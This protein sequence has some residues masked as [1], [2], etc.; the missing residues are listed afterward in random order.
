LTEFRLI[1]VGDLMLGGKVS[2]LLPLEGPD[3]PFQGMRAPFREADC[4]FGNLETPLTDRAASTYV[5]GRPRFAAPVAF[6]ARLARAGFSV[7]SLANNHILDQG[8]M[9]L[10]D[11]VAALDV[12]GVPYIG[13]IEN[14][15]T[16]QRPVVLTRNGVRVGFLAYAQSHCATSSSPGAV[17]AQWDRIVSEVG[18]LRSAVDHVCLSIHAGYEYAPHPGYRTHR[19]FENITRLGVS[20]LLGHH[21]HIPQPMW[22]T[23]EGNLICASLGNCVSDMNDPEVSTACL[24]RAENEGNVFGPKYFA[25]VNWGMA[26]NVLLDAHSVVEA[27]H[28]PLQIGSK[29][30]PS[31]YSGPWPFSLARAGVLRSVLIESYYQ[32]GLL[33]KAPTRRINQLLRQN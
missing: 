11:T 33:L 19:L 23:K 30:E 8:P 4:L 21:P 29:H 22:R 2:R 16:A 32:T 27:A 28:L 12:A 7:V 24:D 18:S 14:S 31:V 6:A 1:A 26:A 25:R 10:E 5:A 3:Y 17:P 13:V 15:R 9:G 20:V